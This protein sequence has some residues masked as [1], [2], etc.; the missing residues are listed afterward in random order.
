MNLSVRLTPS[1]G[2]GFGELS[3]NEIFD[4]LRNERRRYLLH[5]L[6]SSE[7]PVELGKLATLIAAW[8]YDTSVKDVTSTQRK[9]V[10]TTLQQTHL[11]KMDR[12]EIVDYDSNRGLVRQTE[13]TDKVNVYL[14]IG[15]QHEFPWREYYLALGA[16]CCGVVAALWVGVYPLT[17]LSNLG[18]LAVVAIILTVSAVA[19]I[20]HER[21]N[22]LGASEIPPALDR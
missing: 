21:T 14:E 18:W 6:L 7:T 16:V 19:H 15:P 3:K 17:L 8:E 11:P 20:Y 9:R 2:G 10:Y 12:A 22:R 4:I 1:S 5:Y 13:H